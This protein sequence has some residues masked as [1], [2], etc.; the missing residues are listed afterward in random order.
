M[1][2]VPEYGTTPEVQ[3]E[4]S[5]LREQVK[6]LTEERSETACDMLRLIETIK[7]LRGIA[8]RGTGR[9]CGN[10]ETVETF[11]LGYVKTLEEQ[12]K[13]LREA[14]KW[15]WMFIKNGLD[16]G[17]IAPPEFGD[18]ACDILNEIY[19]ALSQTKPKDGE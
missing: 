13:L 2:I 16:L 14:L 15:A 11:V 17:Y 18:P 4:I 9:P 7:Y 12:V 10:T 5:T 3:S 1:S 8:E 6:M 19:K